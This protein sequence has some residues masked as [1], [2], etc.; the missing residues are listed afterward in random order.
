M[1]GG[2]KYIKMFPLKDPADEE[3]DGQNSWNQL[4]G[5][6][7]EI[8]TIARKRALLEGLDWLTLDEVSRE[9]VSGDITE[10]PAPDSN[11]NY[12]EEHWPKGGRNIS[13]TCNWGSESFQKKLQVDDISNHLASIEIV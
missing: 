9:V 3:A 5:W 12:L 6:L 10:P 1:R 8:E 4:R 7:D 13:V 2:Q 11:S